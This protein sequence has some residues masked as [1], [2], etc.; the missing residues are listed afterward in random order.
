MDQRPPMRGLDVAPKSAAETTMLSAT[1]AQETDMFMEVG[2]K[3]IDSGWCCERD[4]LDGSDSEE[5]FL[6]PATDPQILIR[7]I[8]VRSIPRLT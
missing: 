8:A 3:V 6:I 1:Q 4:I 2:R 7:A 5:S